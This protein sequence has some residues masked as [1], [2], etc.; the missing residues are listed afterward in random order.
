MKGKEKE[1][2]CEFGYFSAEEV[3]MWRRDA[4]MRRD[5]LFRRRWQNPRNIPDLV[6]L[7]AA[8]DFEFVVDWYHESGELMDRL[9][10]IRYYDKL[11]K[12]GLDVNK[13]RELQPAI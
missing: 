12:L 2:E 10:D 3:D 7:E 11:L 8:R 4:N 5:Q 1:Q 6:S 13:P 9:R